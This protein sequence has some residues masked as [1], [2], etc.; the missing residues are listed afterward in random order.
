MDH[1]GIT[2]DRVTENVKSVINNV[3]K[4]LSLSPEKKLL[5]VLGQ[6]RLQ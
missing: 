4:R 5:L 2:D 6:H 1:T 3:V